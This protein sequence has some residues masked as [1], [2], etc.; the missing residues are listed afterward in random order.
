MLDLAGQVAALAGTCAPGG[1]VAG[2]GLRIIDARGPGHA[3]PSAESEAAAALALRTAGLVLDPV[4]SAKALGA[5]R[6]LL[7]PQAD[8]PRATTVFWHTGGLLDAVAGW[9]PLRQ[10]RTPERTPS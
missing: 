3:L 1:A 10:N 5:V 7:G 6:E 8:D 4:Y 2:D 9:M